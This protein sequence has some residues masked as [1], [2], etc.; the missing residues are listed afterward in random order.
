M[1]NKN[2]KIDYSQFQDKPLKFLWFVM[3]QKNSLELLFLKMVK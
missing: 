1:Q 2:Q 3:K